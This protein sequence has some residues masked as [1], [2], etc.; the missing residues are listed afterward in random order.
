MVCSRLQSLLL[1]FAICCFVAVP[2]AQKGAPL[3]PLIDHGKWGYVDGDGK[4]VVTPKCD[5]AHECHEGL[6]EVKLGEK[7]GYVDAQGR[8]A[9][10][11]SIHLP[12]HSPRG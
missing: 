12:M 2:D 10:A 8:V 5:Y 7:W 1:P 3:L 6:A 4:W 11:S 9:F